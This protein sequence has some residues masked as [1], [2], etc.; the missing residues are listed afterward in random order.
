MFNALPSGSPLYILGNR[1]SDHLLSRRTAF[2]CFMWEK[3]ITTE[4]IVI[5]VEMLCGVSEPSWSFPSFCLPVLVMA[6]VVATGRAVGSIT[7]MMFW[8]SQL[9]VY[10]GWRASLIRY[11]QSYLSL[12]SCAYCQLQLPGVTWTDGKG[13]GGTPG[14][15]FSSCAQEGMSSF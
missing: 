13:R 5:G 7:V 1:V 4:E 11:G 2:S 14:G 6:L 8:H 9:F 10:T 3:K 15:T 12:S